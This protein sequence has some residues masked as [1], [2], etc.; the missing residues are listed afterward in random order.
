MADAAK[1]NRELEELP[2][3]TEAAAKKARFELYGFM[4]VLEHAKP[5]KNISKET[6]EADRKMAQF[7]KQWS[8]GMAFNE[9]IGQW[10]LSFNFKNSP[11]IMAPIFS[12]IFAMEEKLKDIR[13]ADF[14]TPEVNKRTAPTYGEEALPSSIPTI[15]SFYA[16]ILDKIPPSDG[17][18]VLLQYQAHFPDPFRRRTTQEDF[19]A[20]IAVA[21]GMSLEDFFNITG[22]RSFVK[23]CWDNAGYLLSNAGFNGVTSSAGTMPGF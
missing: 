23:M 22:M 21:C 10:V 9:Y 4:T 19:A 16:K 11:S 6:L 17:K 5:E 12:A 1:H 20:N 15:D 18:N 8:I 13:A 14:G 3:P 7:A 2:F